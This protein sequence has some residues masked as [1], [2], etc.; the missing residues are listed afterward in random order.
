MFSY[1]FICVDNVGPMT[2]SER[3]MM[4]KYQPSWEFLENMSP[5]RNHVPWNHSIWNEL[6]TDWI[7]CIFAGAIIATCPDESSLN[8][9]SNVIMDFNMQTQLT[10]KNLEKSLMN[11]VETRSDRSDYCVRKTEC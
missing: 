2:I 9:S 7:W 4:K 8:D 10:L 6:P 5:A 3:V 11:L 1:F